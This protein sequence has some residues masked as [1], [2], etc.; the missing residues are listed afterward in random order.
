MSGLETWW[1]LL[2]VQRCER[3]CEGIGVF[4]DSV[5][6]VVKSAIGMRPAAAMNDWPCLRWRA[7]ILRTV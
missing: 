3:V 2:C 7:L 6:T 1:Q 5:V 4:G